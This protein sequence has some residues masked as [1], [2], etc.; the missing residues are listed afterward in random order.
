MSLEKLLKIPKILAKT[1]M[2]TSLISSESLLLRA[3]LF[4]TLVNSSNTSMRNSKIS[5]TS[6]KSNKNHHH[7]ELKKNRGKN[8][9]SIFLSTFVNISKHF[10]IFIKNSETLDQISENFSLYSQNS[11]SN[12]RQ[13]SIKSPQQS[14][15][16]ISQHHIQ[17]QKSPQIH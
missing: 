2:G 11:S 17:L 7:F 3:R 9:R 12:L 10:K 14:T 1:S 4:E 8:S 6:V 13:I 5:P 16:Q 15:P